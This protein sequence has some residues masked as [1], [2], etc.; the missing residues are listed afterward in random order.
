M[1]DYAITFDEAVARTALHG[2]LGLCHELQ[3][4]GALEAAAINRIGDFMVQY[5]DVVSPSID[6]GEHLRGWV[7]SNFKVHGA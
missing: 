5:V 4:A 1:A 3:K 7:S 2:L 6:G